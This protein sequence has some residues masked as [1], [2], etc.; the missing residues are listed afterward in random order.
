MRK[1]LCRTLWGSWKRKTD[2]ALYSAWPPVAKPTKGQVRLWRHSIHFFQTLF[3]SKDFLLHFFSV[4]KCADSTVSHTD[5]T[6]K[7]IVNIPGR[8]KSKLIENNLF[9][10]LHLFYFRYCRFVKFLHFGFVFHWVFWWFMRNV[11]ILY[12]IFRQH[13]E[14]LFLDHGVFLTLI[15]VSKLKW[16]V[17]TDIPYISGKQSWF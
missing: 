3:E 9:Y 10:W 1:H 16:T 7:K 2:T 17:I 15:Y 12:S 6:R 4:R 8:R 14:I 5:S 13:M 11:K